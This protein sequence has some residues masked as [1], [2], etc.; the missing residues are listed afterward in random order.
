MP[1]RWPWNLCP[2]LNEATRT[3]ARSLVRLMLMV[4][5]FTMV[6]RSAMCIR[7]GCRINIQA[8]GNDSVVA[9]CGT[10]TPPCEVRWHFAALPLV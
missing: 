2:V 4:G 3:T 9:M 8:N 6:F 1:H 7:M 5:F 10:W